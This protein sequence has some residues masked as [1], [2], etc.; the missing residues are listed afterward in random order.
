MKKKGKVKAFA[1]SA[2]FVGERSK[3]TKVL[4]ELCGREVDWC[5]TE[6]GFKFEG[7]ALGMKNFIVFYWK[8]RKTVSFS[9]KGAWSA[10]KWT[11][12]QLAGVSDHGYPKELDGNELASS[13]MVSINRKLDWS[14]DHLPLDFT[15]PPEH[16]E[17]LPNVSWKVSD[18]IVSEI[19]S[20]SI[21]LNNISV[22][23]NANSCFLP[24]T[25][26]N[27]ILGSDAFDIAM[28]SVETHED[29]PDT[30]DISM[31]TQ[32]CSF[33]PP[34]STKLCSPDKSTFTETSKKNE[35][36]ARNSAE[37]F[38]CREGDEEYPCQLQCGNHECNARDETVFRVEDDLE[39]Q[40]G[41]NIV[42]LPISDIHS[43]PDIISQI[44]VKGNSSSTISPCWANSAWRS[45]RINGQGLKQ[46][47]VNNVSTDC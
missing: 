42:N 4:S 2:F 5:P 8:K 36:D 44:E 40:N 37:R 15:Q 16:L 27:N 28:P 24:N 33:V 9:G 25:K 35:M 41:N 22:M 34:I 19:N 31:P 21:R 6:H 23:G 14:D 26:L 17:S 18:K 45:G 29:E 30:L 39:T 11:L 38:T 3:I 46:T 20:S 32:D 13:D 1:T 7:E 43:P 12:D 10:K 47:G